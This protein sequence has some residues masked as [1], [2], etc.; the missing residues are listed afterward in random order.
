MLKCLLLSGILKQAHFI[1]FSRKDKDYISLGVCGLGYIYLL[2]VC[3]PAQPVFMDLAV[4]VCVCGLPSHSSEM[5][6]REALIVI[7]LG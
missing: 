4:G 3:N 2:K 5:H 6:E 7:E 1:L